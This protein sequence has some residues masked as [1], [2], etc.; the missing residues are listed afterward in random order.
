MSCNPTAFPKMVLETA[1]EIS[2]HRRTSSD[3]I[4]GDARH[5]AEI[6]DHDP[7]YRGIPHAVDVSEST[8]GAPFWNSNYSI[9]D[10]HAWGEKIAQRIINGDEKRVKYLVSH[11]YSTGRAKIFDPSIGKFYWRDQPG[12]NHASHLHISFLS[13]SDLSVEDS[14]VPFFVGA[15]SSG[16]NQGVSGMPKPTDTVAA[17]SN[18]FG[19][20]RLTANGGIY[21]DRGQFYGSYLSLP[22]AARQGSRYFVSITE[23][24]DDSTKE[25][26]TLWANDGADYTFPLGK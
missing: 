17:L 18:H 8:P 15:I 23:R 4:C 21:T 24:T 9:F 13:T 25:G 3:G 10:A 22:S 5:R 2:N 7:D 6:S 14:T 19:S 26:Y 12:D 1:T 20:W 16:N 11:D